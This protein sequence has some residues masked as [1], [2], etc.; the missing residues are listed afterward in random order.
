MTSPDRRRHR[1]N[2]SYGSRQQLYE[3]SE[4]D[5]SGSS[6]NEEAGTITSGEGGGSGAGFTMRNVFLALI[7]SLLL[8]FVGLPLVGCCS[9]LGFC[10][11]DCAMNPYGFIV[12][13]TFVTLRVCIDGPSQ[14]HTLWSALIFGNRK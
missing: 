14:V 6:D 5:D 1:R 11:V 9:V 7:A 13:F 4:E 8:F 12:I 3:A 10:L 2:L